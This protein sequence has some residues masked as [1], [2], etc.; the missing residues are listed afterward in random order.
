MAP[1]DVLDTLADVCELVVPARLVLQ[2]DELEGVAIGLF[3]P[4]GVPG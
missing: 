3:G 2:E 1:D 4:I